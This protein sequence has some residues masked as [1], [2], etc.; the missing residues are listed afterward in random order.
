MYRKGK[1]HVGTAGRPART[2]HALFL[3]KSCTVLN[4]GLEFELIS[5]LKLNL[6]SVGLGLP[7][8]SL[9]QNR[10]HVTLN[11]LMVVSRESTYCIQM[12][13]TETT[14]VCSCFICL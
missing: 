3:L 14:G 9:D 2:V 13:L 10:E 12:Y 1:Q 8:L 7:T 4:P 11:N 5:V 6:C